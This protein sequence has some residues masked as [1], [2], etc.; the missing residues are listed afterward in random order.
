MLCI[1]MLFLMVVSLYVS[2]GMMMYSSESYHL[3]QSI[4]QNNIRG[5]NARYLLYKLFST[6]GMEP[7]SLILEK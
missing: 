5:Q 7:V 6:L 1:R 2:R 3:K 4:L